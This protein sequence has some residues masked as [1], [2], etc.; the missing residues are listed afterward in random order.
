MA[1]FLS[2]REAAERLGVTPQHLRRLIESGQLAAERVGHRYIV[3]GDSLEALRAAREALAHLPPGTLAQIAQ[4]QRMLAQFPWAAI[5][6]AQRV[7][8]QFESSSAA[9]GVRAVP[10]SEATFGAT[11]AWHEWAGSNR[12]QDAVAKLRARARARTHGVAAECTTD[13]LRALREGRHADA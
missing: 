2:T 12:P 7:I 10:Q 8:A 6:E 1:G 13:T 5:R 3:D 9:T 4:A 11:A